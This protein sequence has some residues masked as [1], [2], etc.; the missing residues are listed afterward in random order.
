MGFHHHRHGVPC[1][2]PHRHRHNVLRIASPETVTIGRR[3]PGRGKGL[4]AMTEQGARTLTDEVVAEIYRLLWRLS[5]GDD[6]DAN[7]ITR[8]METG[9]RRAVHRTWTAPPSLHGPTPAGSDEGA[10]D[11]MW[12]AVTGGNWIGEV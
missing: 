7:P 2:I 4:G 11:G 8:E 1:L 12:V 5:P 3:L 9:R 10:V 6:P